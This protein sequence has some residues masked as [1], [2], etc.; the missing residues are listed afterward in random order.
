MTVSMEQVH[1]QKYDFVHKT[2]SNSHLK[3]IP[4]ANHPGPLENI[5]TLQRTAGNQA[6]QRLLNS[7]ALQA[8]LQISQ[9]SDFYEQEADR[10]AEHVM[11]MPEPASQRKCP[12]DKNCPLEDEEKEKGFVQL[13]TEQAPYGELT[14]PDDLISNAA[15]L[16]V[17]HDVSCLPVIDGGAVVGI[18][19]RH[20]VLTGIR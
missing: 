6:V 19:D 1:R 16:L 5:L 11:R 18:V 8:K 12:D 13:K 7:G 17:Q 2:K 14:A 20:D 9:P 15:R 10:V 4:S 3:K